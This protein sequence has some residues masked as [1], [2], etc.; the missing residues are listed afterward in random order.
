MSTEQKNVS[1]RIHPSLDYRA[2]LQSD[3]RYDLSDV[4]PQTGH[5][6]LNLS[7]DKAEIIEFEL[8]PRC[9]NLAR[10][11]LDFEIEVSLPAYEEKGSLDNIHV[12]SDCLSLIER[13]EVFTR[14]G[15]RLMDLE[16]QQLWSKLSN[17]YFTDPDSY[18]KSEIYDADEKN[19]VHMHNS[20]NSWLAVN[21]DTKNAQR[22]VL[23]VAT[24]VGG[25]RNFDTWQIRSPVV[26][27]G[28]ISKFTRKY[29]IDLGMF[30][31]S[32]LAVDKSL[33]FGGQVLQIKLHMAGYNDYLTTT[34]GSGPNFQYPTTVTQLPPLVTD[35]QLNGRHI[36]DKWTGSGVAVVLNNLNIRCAFE[37]N[38]VLIAQ[39][40]AKVMSEKGLKLFIPFVHSFQEARTA[41]GGG[42][43]TQI[44]RLNR[45][46][47][48]RIQRLVFTTTGVQTHPSVKLRDQD[49][50]MGTS[51]YRCTK[52]NNFALLKARVQSL[53]TTLNNRRLQE[54][55]I[56]IQDSNNRFTSDAFDYVK[57][58][59]TKSLMDTIPSQLDN[60]A[61]IDS[62]DAYHTKKE[63]FTNV[64]AGLP[65]SD[66]M[67]YAVNCKINGDS[68][69]TTV[70]LTTF[71]VCQRSMQLKADS[72]SIV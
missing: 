26:A 48:L 70:R 2:R 23:G 28:V 44:T 20:A 43:L 64:V 56:I 1:S 55:D 32:I 36:S 69:A 66:D 29:T 19:V 67:Q 40:K 11:K 60:W 72:I 39:I 25:L 6:T 33:Y 12:R 34:I 51:N 61:H 57:P 46:H 58:I 38:P 14:S 41:S 35:V 16:R 49:A 13:V 21:S 68:G 45:G 54:R 4:Y 17:S 63:D 24:G 52:S 10:S 31:D 37:S 8:P 47:G 7:A 42:A 3:P 9:I 15:T 22:D 18:S 50:K 65:L 62:F 5:R 59:V 30:R 27:T 53:Y 71:A